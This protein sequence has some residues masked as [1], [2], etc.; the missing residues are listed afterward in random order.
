MV[1]KHIKWIA[2]FVVNVSDSDDGGLLF[3]FVVKVF[4]TKINIMSST[5][6]D[7]V[8]SHVF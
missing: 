3:F 2:T 7:K 5:N 8:A 6:N 1:Q 4:E